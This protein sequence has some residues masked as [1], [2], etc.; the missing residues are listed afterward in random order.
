MP[1]PRKCA[2]ESGETFSENEDSFLKRGLGIRLDEF[3]MNASMMTPSWR[4]QLAG[5]SRRYLISSLVLLVCL[6][7]FFLLCR[8]KQMP[9]LVEVIRKGDES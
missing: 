9:A 1:R 2:F 6:F 7:C 5:T 4:K 8:I 3:E